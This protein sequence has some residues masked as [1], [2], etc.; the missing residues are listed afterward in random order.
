MKEWQV[1]RNFNINR[2]ICNTFDNHSIHQ[3]YVC[4]NPVRFFQVCCV[5][6]PTRLVNTPQKI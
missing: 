3:I 1:I 6:A 5:S 4:T 2:R